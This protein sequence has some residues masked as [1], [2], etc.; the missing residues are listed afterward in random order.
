MSFKSW[1]SYWA[2]SRAT[3]HGNRYI[4]DKEVTSFLDAVLAT[5][6]ERERAVKKGSIFW[7]AQLGNDWRPI[8][9][10]DE[11]IGEEPCP[12]QRKQMKPIPYSATEGRANPKG[13][14][15]LYLATDKETAMSEVRPWLSSS[16][17]VGQ[18]KTNKELRL[19]DCSVHHKKE[20]V[21]YFEEPSDE[22]RELSVWSHIDNAFSEPVNPSDQ[23]SDYVPTQIIAELFKSE[24]FDGIAYKSSLSTGFNVVLFDLGVA[25]LINCFLYEAES[26]EF[27]FKE[28]ANPY[29]VRNSNEQIDTMGGVEVVEKPSDEK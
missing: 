11:E 18:F 10:D 20:V 29:L 19:I 15:Y 22:E 17:S 1:N 25:D 3:R 13:I 16:I 26:I 4:H 8:F 14:P 2:F 23:I 28:T 12:Y 21:F 9:Q 5:S 6:E 7:R 27:K 24:G